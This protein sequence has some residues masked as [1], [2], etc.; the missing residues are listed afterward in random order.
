[1]NFPAVARNL[2]LS[3]HSQHPVSEA[4]SEKNM[5]NFLKKT[6]AALIV[7]LAS[8][9]AANAVPITINMTAD[10]VVASGG[11]CF[12]ATCTGGTDWTTLGTIPN[13]GNWR[14]SDTV[15][16]DLAP[17]T[18]W[19]AWEVANFENPSS[20]NPAALLAEILWDGN[21]NYSSSGWEVYDVSTGAFIA[22]ATSYGSNGAP[23]I[24]TSVNGGPV[25]GI[26]SSANWIYTANNFAYADPSAWFRT[27]ITVVPEPTILTLLGMSLLGFGL[28][29]LRR[30]LVTH[31]S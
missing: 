5:R 31:L 10:N 1:M 2:R 23:N 29:R 15:V 12:D 19:F 25:S 8:A 9:G 28:A 21:A 30:P 18:Y 20:D 14:V 3:G 4:M 11:L 27:S 22:N 17:G 26:S 24:W 6:S 13:A 16:L 7:T